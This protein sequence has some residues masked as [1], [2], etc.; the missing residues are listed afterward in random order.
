MAYVQPMTQP[1]PVAD[2]VE[3]EAERQRRI[4]W[5]AAR[6]AEARASAAAGRV[7]SSEEVDAWIDSLDTEHELPPPRSGR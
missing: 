3:T 4:A 1:A 7:V 2:H 6:I 5:E